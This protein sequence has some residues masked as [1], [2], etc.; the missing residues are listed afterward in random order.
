MT[1]RDLPSVVGVGVALSLI[2]LVMPWLPAPSDG[3]MTSELHALRAVAAIVLALAAL[4]VSYRFRRDLGTSLG[5][6]LGAIAILSIATLSLVQWSEIQTSSVLGA[7]ALLGAP[8][9]VVFLAKR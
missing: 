7:A 6:G 9:V 5:A 3:G 8:A 4:F 1:G 2:N